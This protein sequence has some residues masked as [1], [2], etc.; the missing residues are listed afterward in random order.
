MEQGY[1]TLQIPTVQ[2]SLDG[3][4]PKEKLI[5]APDEWFTTLHS[6]CERPACGRETG[7][8]YFSRAGWLANKAKIKKAFK[9]SP[10]PRGS[11]AD[12]ENYE[13]DHFEKMGKGVIKHIKRHQAKIKQL[14]GIV[15]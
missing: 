2:I 3:T 13:T 4:F 1:I 7:Y 8:L 15:I 14:K 11:W 12:F 6:G 5:D 9:S 10:H